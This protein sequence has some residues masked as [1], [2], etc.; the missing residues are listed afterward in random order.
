MKVV[1]SI[2]MIIVMFFLSVVGFKVVEM[3]KKIYKNE[4]QVQRNKDFL[5]G[6]RLVWIKQISDNFD[7]LEKNLYL[8]SS[9][10]NSLTRELYQKK[11]IDKPC[12]IQRYKKT[13]FYL[14]DKVNR[15]R[16]E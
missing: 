5:K 14:E 12:Y 16:G 15:E 4:A 6:I 8:Y 9:V 11:R 3:E 10:I 7:T 2:M 1:I 13:Y